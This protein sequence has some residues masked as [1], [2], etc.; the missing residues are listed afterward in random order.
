MTQICFSQTEVTGQT[1]S[2]FLSSFYHRDREQRN[3]FKYE[4]TADYH[5]ETP[6]A[7]FLSP[8]AYVLSLPLHLP[9][10]PPPPSQSP[11]SFAISLFFLFLFL[12][13]SIYKPSTTPLPLHPPSNHPK[14][15]RMLPPSVWGWMGGFGTVPL[16]LAR[17][18]W[19]SFKST[20]VYAPNL[21]TLCF[22]T[23][24]HKLNPGLM[25]PG[26]PPCTCSEG[27]GE[28]QREQK[29][30]ER[31]RERM[32]KSRVKRKW[33]SDFLHRLCG[34]GRLFICVFLSPLVRTRGEEIVLSTAWGPCWAYIFKPPL[35]LA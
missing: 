22:S 6:W 29:K 9:I 13:L 25:R 4:N 32:R 23:S 18:S 33:F 16:S 11:P 30:R 26:S 2:W 20:H 21:C 31:E 28:R 1:K 15:V 24:R 5:F 12:F 3:V 17:C 8:G 27:E 34:P 7:L 19:F 10:P 14:A 35:F